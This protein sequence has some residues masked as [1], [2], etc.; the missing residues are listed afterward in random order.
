MIRRTPDCVSLPS[1]QCVPRFFLSSLLLLGLAGCTRPGAP[2]LPTPAPVMIT[3]VP[4][5]AGVLYSPEHLPAPAVLVLPG[6]P[7]AVQ[8][9]RPAAER[10]RQ[11]GYL[12]LI[13]EL[14][15]VAAG[16]TDGADLVTALTPAL[17][18]L[19]AHGGDPDNLFV[20]GEDAGSVLALHLARLAPQV[21]GLIMVSPSLSA[22]GLE[23]GEIA[24]LEDCPTLLLVAEQ[25]AYSTGAAATLKEIAPVF[26]EL[27]AYAGGAH[28]PNLFAAAPNALEQLLHWLQTVR[29]EP[30][31]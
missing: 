15:L 20:A 26:C 1:L 28:G 8:E 22:R 31:H 7:R 11:E 4:P 6:T 30:P 12:A 5:L 29:Q 3:E 9:W 2:T 17:A 10:L 16:E 13:M 23:A 14:P 25:D 24:R 27:H 19:I 21:Q 18:W